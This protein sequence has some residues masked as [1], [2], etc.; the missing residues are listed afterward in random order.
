MF[1]L[2]II[3]YCAYTNDY[4]I[5]TIA[6]DI[7][8][9]VNAHFY[10]LREN[11][12]MIVCTKSLW[13]PMT[14][15]GFR[16]LFPFLSSLLSY[17]SFP[18]LLWEMQGCNCELLWWAGN[19]GLSNSI[20]TVSIPKHPSA[21]KRQRNGQRDGTPWLVAYASAGAYRLHFISNS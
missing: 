10:L 4:I 7:T 1:F 9:T 17:F 5:P 16:V 21:L 6:N 11:V 19:H 18:F 12:W 3:L 15:E 8:T 14:G 13:Q 20:K 2:H